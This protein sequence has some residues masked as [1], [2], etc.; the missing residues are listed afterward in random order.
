[1]W[2]RQVGEHNRSHDSSG[3]LKTQSNRYTVQIGADLAQWNFTA[4][5]RLY[6]GMMAGY[7]HSDSRTDSGVSG[8]SAKGRVSG[9][10]FGPYATWYEDIATRV[11]AYVDSW[12][13][14]NTFDN[15]VAGQDLA[16]ENYTSRGV[17]ASLESGYS[18]KLTDNGALSSWVQPKMQIVWSNITADDHTEANGT[19]VHQQTQ[20]NVMTRL[21]VRTWL[22]G[23]SA[24][25]ADTGRE[26]Q[27]FVETSWLHNT[28][29]WSIRMD[30]TT[31]Y[32]DGSRNIAELKVGVEG[33]IAPTIDMWG[34]VTQQLGDAGYSSTQAMLGIKYRF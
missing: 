2:L 13:L 18:I 6:A 11:G 31:H 16:R 30:D 1:M 12:L 24:Y 34:N 14:Y 29:N 32:I 8:Y 27:P 17:Q 28:H 15:T 22:R 26:F 5:D 3:Q 7:G 33:H 4:K 10:S 23:H 21:G 25:D 20:S 9:Y 19:R